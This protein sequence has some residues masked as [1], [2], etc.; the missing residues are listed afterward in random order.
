MFAAIRLFS[1]IGAFSAPAGGSALSEL[2]TRDGIAERI[3]ALELSHIS[4]RASESDEPFYASLFPVPEA[5]EN[6]SAPEPEPEAKSKFNPK[7]NPGSAAP[8]PEDALP[9]PPRR[10]APPTLPLPTPASTESAPAYSENGGAAGNI[11]VRNNSGLE[12]DTSKLL[13]EPYE[14]KLTPGEPSVLIVHTHGSEAYTRAPGETYEE[15]DTYRTEDKE[16]SIIRVGDELAA[17]LAELGVSAVH[18]REIYDYPSYAG[19]YGRSLEA[20]KRSLEKYPSIRLVID[21]HRDAIASPDGSQFKTIAD[22]NGELCSQ[23]MLVVGTNGSGLQHPG[24]RDNMKLALRLQNEMNGR[25]PTLARPITAAK[26]RYNQHL[27]PGSLIVEV[28]AAGNTLSESLS[29]VRHF[30]EVYA[31]VIE[32]SS[33]PP[34]S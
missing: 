1:A 19:A 34:R 11:I 33:T 17:A 26:Y 6:E 22:I 4:A 9:I 14:I 25:F 28:G 29:A 15:S 13:S 7:F 24:W 5:G 16:Y 27:T 30:A 23:I 20:T 18:D 21:L 10:A 2:L 31:A 12:F 8:L 32:G 3:L